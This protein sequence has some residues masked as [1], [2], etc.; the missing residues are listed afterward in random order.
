MISFL[1]VIVIYVFAFSLVLFQHYREYPLDPEN[2]I[3]YREQLYKT[4]DIIYGKWDL[5]EY[6]QVMVPFFLLV[7]LFLPLVLLNMLI[8]IMGSTYGSVMET[9]GL[10]DGQEKLGM[11]HE[12]MA[13]RNQVWKFWQALKCAKRKSQEEYK[14]VAQIEDLGAIERETEKRVFLVSVEKADHDDDQ[15]EYTIARLT[16]RMKELHHEISS[17]RA[18]LSAQI[19]N[20]IRGVAK[21]Q[22][23]TLSC[24]K[25]LLGLPAQGTKTSNEEIAN[26]PTSITRE[27]DLLQG[28]QP[29]KSILP[30]GDSNLE[31]EDEEDEE[32]SES[33]AADSKL[34]AE[35]ETREPDENAQ[36]LFGQ[37]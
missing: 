37:E 19:K 12:V 18:D 32:S 17:V 34:D 5:G 6:H 35:G 28:C 16:S 26:A 9:R 3:T 20:E 11:I 22:E 25:K 4:Y 1:I 15:E 29:D 13:V 8:A 24:V 23:E 2:P 36:N 27:R 21:V 14:R 30:E 31:D 33:A 10:I 7:S